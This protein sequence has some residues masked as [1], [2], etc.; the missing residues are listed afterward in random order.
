MVWKGRMGLVQLPSLQVNFTSARFC[1][2]GLT[3][4]IFS[5]PGYNYLGFD[6]IGDLAFSSPFGMLKAAKDIAPVA[7]SKDGAMAAYGGEG[8]IVDIEYLS[9]ARIM[10]ERGDHAASV[11]VLPPWVRMLL[12]NFH[13]W[14]RKGSVALGNL[15]G[16]A[17]AAVSRRLKTPTDQRD[18]FSKLQQGKDEGGEPM[19]RPELTAEAVT[20]LVGGSDTTSK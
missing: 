19:G 1:C 11:G 13:P 8:T 17:I 9:G 10:N 18:I 2:R 7:R 5:S 15:N 6:I 12:R 3:P 14:Y 16:L 20:Q 4:P